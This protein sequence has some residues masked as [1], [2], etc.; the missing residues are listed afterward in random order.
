MKYNLTSAEASK[1]LKKLLEEKNIILSNERQS[2]V[3]NASLGE[4][5]ESVRPA[6]D[7][8]ATQKAIELLDR[9]IRLL[10]HAV[11]RFN[12]SQTVG[13]TGMTI[14]QVL[15]LIPQ[16][17]ETRERL[18][19]L[20]KRLPKQRASVYGAGSNAVIDYKYANYSVEQANKDYIR[21]SDELRMLQTALD[22]VNTTVRLEF[23]LPD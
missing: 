12:S 23:E 3:F 19:D 8:E 15:I 14:D 18:Y 4:D 2:A 1:L 7:Y 13:D 21:V 9:K 5:I 11:N 16:L 20:Q 10:K 6:Y 17:T 22:L